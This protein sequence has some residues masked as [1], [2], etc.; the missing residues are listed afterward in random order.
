[1][2]GQLRT[3]RRL[4]SSCKNGKKRSNIQLKRRRKREVPVAQ[5][6]VEGGGVSQSC[7]LVKVTFRSGVS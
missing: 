1:M 4:E 7:G 3:V 6:C 5:L 2:K